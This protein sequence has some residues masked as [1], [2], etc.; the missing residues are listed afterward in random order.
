L[1]RILTGSEAIALGAIQAGVTFVAGINNSAAGMNDVGVYDA[2][3]KITGSSCGSGLFAN[4]CAEILSVLAKEA[5]AGNKSFNGVVWP[6]NEKIAVEMAAGAVF[7]GARALIVMDQA[8][9][10]IASDPLIGLNFLNANTPGA[11]TGALVVVVAGD[12]PSGQDCRLFA[13]YA[14]LT[15]FDPSGPEEAYLM[16]ADAFDHS[17]KI[18][19]PVFLK[20]SAKICRSYASVNLEFVRNEKPAAPVKEDDFSSYRGNTLIITPENTGPRPEGSLPGGAGILG[21]AS[22][23]LA[24]SYVM[25]ILSPLPPALKILKIS[26]FPI[27]ENLAVRFLEGLD[28]IL[29]VEEHGHVIEDELLKICGSRGFRTNVQGKR[30]GIVSSDEDFTLDFTGE[31]IEV[32]L[33]KVWARLSDLEKVQVINA[34]PGANITSEASHSSLSEIPPEVLAAAV[35]KAGDQPKPLPPVPPLPRRLP[36]PCAERRDSACIHEAGFSVLREAAQKFSGGKKTVFYGDTGCGYH[37][38]AGAPALTSL[39]AASGISMV[40]GGNKETVAFACMGEPAFFHSGLTGLVNAVSNHSDIIIVVFSNPASRPVFKLNVSVGNLASALGV[41]DIIT[42]SPFDKMNA[43][44]AVGSLIDKKGVRLV[45][46][47]TPPEG[48]PK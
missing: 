39:S 9:I 24:S 44:I 36:R 25:E 13:A 2:G 14:K 5:A 15:V 48:G 1:K 43:V 32:F 6:L 40:M 38:I 37:G 21:I 26:T 16:M 33:R 46:L 30:F 20:P 22:G 35:N 3:G 11:N 7:S 42:I 28:E 19:R 23:G 41:K 47:E 29:V 4:P 18:G 10:N 31:V 45:I 34:T 12:L 8:G 17:A 27:P